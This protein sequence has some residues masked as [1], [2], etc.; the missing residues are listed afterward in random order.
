MYAD[1]MLDALLTSQTEQRIGRTLSA[2]FSLKDISGKVDE[3][4]TRTL[5]EAVWF[6]LLVRYMLESVF[7]GHS[8]VELSASETSGINVRL[9]PGRTSYRSWGCSSM[10]ARPTRGT[11]TERCASTARTC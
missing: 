1:V 4:A 9:I 3:G 6:P 11:I 5:S 2:G 8:L 7:Y 10:T